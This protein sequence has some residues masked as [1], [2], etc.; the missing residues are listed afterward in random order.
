MDRRSF[1]HSFI[2]GSVIA[3]SAPQIVTHG[4]HLRK[5]MNHCNFMLNPEWVDAKYEW[6]VSNLRKP[7]VIV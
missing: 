5:R 7:A 1:L 6:Y 3:I 2:K 4:L